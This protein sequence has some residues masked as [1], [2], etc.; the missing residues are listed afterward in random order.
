MAPVTFLFYSHQNPPCSPVLVLASDMFCLHRHVCHGADG[1]TYYHS[2]V[3][4]LVVPPAL[5]TFWWFRDS[6]AVISTSVPPLSTTLVSPVPVT[7]PIISVPPASISV[8]AVTVTA[9]TTTAAATVA[10]PVPVVVAIS[11]SMP[12]SITIAIITAVPV[13]SITVATV[14][15]AP[16]IFTMPVPILLWWRWR[17]RWRE[18]VLCTGLTDRRTDWAQGA[19]TSK[20]RHWE[21]WRRLLWNMRGFW[22]HRAQTSSTGPAWRAVRLGAELW[23][24]TGCSN[25]VA[26]VLSLQE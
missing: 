10:I 23:R 11:V 5:S 24:T 17:G 14:P 4:I 8:T 9:A 21:C 19:C 15:V 7:S 22:R 18:A 3:F 25:K 2:D 26:L 1:C 12:V 13:A 16:T 6:K 20:A